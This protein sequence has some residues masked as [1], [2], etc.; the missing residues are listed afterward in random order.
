MVGLALKFLRVADSH[1]RAPDDLARYR[2]ILPAIL[3]Q[4]FG[5]G[6]SSAGLGI[7][8]GVDLQSRAVMHAAMPWWSLP[9]TMRAAV[10]VARLKET[11]EQGPW[12]NILGQCFNAFVQHYVRR[13]SDLMA[14][15]TIG[16]DGQPIDS[17]P[18]T[19]DV[20]PAY[21]TG[22]SLLDVLEYPEV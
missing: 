17:I 19:P 3:R 6:L 12:L 22:L 14:V 8:K 11:E 7:V 16:P 10:E 15:Q 20:D 21:H 13:D 4:N 5:T 2:E 1:G 18:A 9:E